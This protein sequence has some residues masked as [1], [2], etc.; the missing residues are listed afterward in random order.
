MPRGGAQIPGLGKRIGRPPKSQ[1]ELKAGKGIASEVLAMNAPPLDHKLR[2]KCDVCADHRERKCKCIK[3][4]DQALPKECELYAEHYVCHCEKCG[5]W[6]GLLSTDKR[7]RFE[8]RR[9]LTDRRDGR[10]AQGV[11]V[12]DTRE[13]ARELDFGDLPELVTPSESGS[14]RKPN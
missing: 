1:V 5:W 11:F 14:T 7:L 13:N 4:H 10:P 3:V 9:Y 2:C 12:G 6:E 8:T